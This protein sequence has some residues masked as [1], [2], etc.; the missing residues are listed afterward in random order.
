VDTECSARKSKR[1]ARLTRSA[2]FQFPD[3]CVEKIE[4]HYDRKLDRALIT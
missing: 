1:L 4:Y 2:Q 3:A